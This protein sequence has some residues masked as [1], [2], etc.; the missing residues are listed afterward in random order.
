M[1]SVWLIDMLS[2]M[3]LELA[4]RR[5]VVATM[6]LDRGLADALD[7]VED[8]GAF[9]VA[10]GVAQNAPEQAD[11]VPQPDIF[12]KGCAFLAAAGFQP[13]F[14]KHDLRRHR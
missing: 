6:E 2:R 14:R 3:Q 12:L 4:P 5:L 10:D 13:V 8:I 11:V 9:L 7:Q 1:R